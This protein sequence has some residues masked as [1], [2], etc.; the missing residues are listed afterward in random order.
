MFILWMSFNSL[1]T[2]QL[3]IYKEINIISKMGHSTCCPSGVYN[4][5]EDFDE[6]EKLI[7]L[8]SLDT[9]VLEKLLQIYRG[10]FIGLICRNKFLGLSEIVLFVL[11][12][13]IIGNLGCTCH[14]LYE[15]DLEKLSLWI[16]LEVGQCLVEA[17]TFCLW[18]RIGSTS[19][20]H[21]SLV[22]R[23]SKAMKQ[24]NCSLQ[25]Y[26]YILVW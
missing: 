14:Y 25:I 18:L 5:K 21:L 8:K 19:W 26:G 16:L 11:V 10:M 17:V 15:A 22:R 12:S 4:K 20:V 13:Q 9:L 1:R 24:W 6:W 23:S 2:K 3:L 7:L